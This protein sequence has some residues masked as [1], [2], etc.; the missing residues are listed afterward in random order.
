MNGIMNSTLLPLWTGVKLPECESWAGVCGCACSMQGLMGDQ[1][2]DTVYLCGLCMW[3]AGKKQ[4]EGNRHKAKGGGKGRVKGKK[5][6][7]G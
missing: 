3:G 1:Q 6:Q 2:T 5:E 7:S 4:G